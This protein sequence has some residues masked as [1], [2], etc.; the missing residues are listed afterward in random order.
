MPEQ[1]A[2]STPQQPSEAPV[3]GNAEGQAAPSGDAKPD[4][5]SLSPLGES[6]KDVK[7][8]PTIA[9]KLPSFLKSEHLTPELFD[10]LSDPTEAKLFFS[11]ISGYR[12][13]E[14]SRLE[15]AANRQKE[16]DAI[17]KSLSAREISILAKEK[18][19]LEIEG[20]AYF[21]RDEKVKRITRDAQR[22]ADELGLNEE[23]TQTYV[24][25]ATK[26]YIEAA[27]DAHQKQ[28]ADKQAKIESIMAENDKI[29]ATVFPR[30]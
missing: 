20:D 1:E 11:D 13:A 4:M 5:F 25:R 30:V 6:W 8:N 16:L 19:L 27:K 9:E 22:E 28:V 21:A 2:V 24:N 17:D 10:Y 15:A 7:I 3:T 18:E 29:A 12:K 23:R 26:P 14:N